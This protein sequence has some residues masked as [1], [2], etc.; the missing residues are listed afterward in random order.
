MPIFINSRCILSSG[1]RHHGA[2]SHRATCPH[3]RFRSFDSI[4]LASRRVIRQLAARNAR[5]P[6][7]AEHTLCRLVFF[8]PLAH[9]NRV[10]K[11]ADGIQHTR[12]HSPATHTH[13]YC[14]ELSENERMQAECDRKEGERIACR[15]NKR[16]KFMENNKSK[17]PVAVLFCFWPLKT[18][19]NVTTRVTMDK[20]NGFC[21]SHR[22]RQQQ[23]QVVCNGGAACRSKR[24]ESRVMHE[25]RH[26]VKRHHPNSIASPNFG[27]CCFFLYCFNY[28]SLRMFAAK[29]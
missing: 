13:T 19:E 15:P 14:V 3:I 2:R 7:R 12:T 24:A 5:Y 28:I 10:S 22:Q 23:Q 27:V 18:P 26:L 6:P 29:L 17:V 16:N 21:S 1:H 25:K 8:L 9:L 11:L 20:R 4:R